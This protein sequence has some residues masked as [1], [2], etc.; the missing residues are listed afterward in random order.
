MRNLSRNFLLISILA[1]TAAAYSS[2]QGTLWYKGKAYDKIF[3]ATDDFQEIIPGQVV[4]QGLH[5]RIN[6]ETGK[7]E[8]KKIDPQDTVTYDTVQ[9]SRGDT[10]VVDYHDQSAGDVVI[11]PDEVIVPSPQ[12]IKPNPHLPPHIRSKFEISLAQIQELSEIDEALESLEELSH[13]VEFGERIINNATVSRLLYFINLKELPSRVR[14]LSAIILG[15]SLQNNPNACIKASKI[16]DKD[17]RVDLVRSLIELLN[18]EPDL[19]VKR[20]IMYAIA[21]AAKIPGSHQYLITQDGLQRLRSIFEKT[22]DS[23]LRLKMAAFIEDEFL[24]QDMIDDRL[25]LEDELDKKLVM[26]KYS[27]LNG[28]SQNTLEEELGKWCNQFLAYSARLE[29]D[30]DD[31]VRFDEAITL[32]RQR[33]PGIC[34]QESRPSS[35]I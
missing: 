25:R 4:P 5:Y 27:G 20:N 8:A 10:G 29:D 21:R 22:E 7:Q 28:V 16:V 35:G 19:K 13:E 3:V 6:L 1:V 33:Y 26:N 15:N 17:G 14:A 32:M 24:N 11:V 2:D 23:R 18:E 34:R 31:L 12:S 9:V 30:Q